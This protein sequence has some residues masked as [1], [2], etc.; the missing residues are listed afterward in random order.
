MIHRNLKPYARRHHVG[1]KANNFRDAY[2]LAYFIMMHGEGRFYVL[3]QHGVKGI[4]IGA[5]SSKRGLFENMLGVQ[6][7]DL[8]SSG[9][10]W[11]RNVH[12]AADRRTREKRLKRRMRNLRGGA[13][14]NIKLMGCGDE[15]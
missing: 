15:S 7:G 3:V 6:C 9:K 11:C 2:R 13:K 4:V 5:A 8:S 12:R 10:A 1:D 14:G